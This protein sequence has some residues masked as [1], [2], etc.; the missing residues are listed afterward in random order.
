MRVRVRGGR[1]GGKRTDGIAREPFTVL[2]S[3]RG[4]SAFLHPRNPIAVKP[5]M[6]FNEEDRG[7]EG[8]GG[9]E[10]EAGV[11]SGA[12]RRT[13]AN[14]MASIIQHSLLLDICNGK[15]T[16]ADKTIHKMRACF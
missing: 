12:H 2:G 6:H 11:K 8:G 3:Q 4:K 15:R 16:T 9:E 14:F 1:G 5:L 13:K 10:G 7:G